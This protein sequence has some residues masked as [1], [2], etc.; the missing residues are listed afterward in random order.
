MLKELTVSDTYPSAQVTGI[1]LSPIQPDWVPPNLHFI[2][3][4][5][6]DEWVY[7]AEH[8]DFIH[9]RHTLHS[10]QKPVILMERTFK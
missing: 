3:D 1:D 6:E 2:L 5:F 8:F 4:D 9:M 10:V 7:P